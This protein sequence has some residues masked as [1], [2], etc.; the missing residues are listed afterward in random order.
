MKIDGDKMT[1]IKE[2]KKVVLFVCTGNTCRSPMAAAIFNH[3][4][5]QEEINWF[6]RS[7]GI[8]TE[9]GLPIS[10]DAKTAI[11]EYGIYI[12]DHMSRQ[13]DERMLIDANIVLTMTKTQ[14]D[15]LHIYFPEKKDKVFSVAEFTDF[16][17]DIEDPYGK[18]LEKYQETAK[19]LMEIIPKVLNVLTS[20]N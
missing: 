1:N 4:A 17:G 14:R 18:G 7:A 5:E 13:L 19:I 16:H 11:N 9:T 3:F 10:D 12:E 8:A 6:A 15:L 20:Q 2:T